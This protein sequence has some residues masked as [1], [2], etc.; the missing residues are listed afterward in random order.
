[1]TVVYFST[2]RIDDPSVENNQYVR[3]KK[4]MKELVRSSGNPYLI[5]RTSNIVGIA[6]NPFTI[7]NYLYSKIVAGEQFDL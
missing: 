3:H 5:V 2:Y 7:T 6:D 1:M 4:E